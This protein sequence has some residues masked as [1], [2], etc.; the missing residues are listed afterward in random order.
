MPRL[1][2]KIKLTWAEF[3]TQRNA[4]ERFELYLPTLKL[5]Q[6]QLQLTI[7][8]TLQEHVALSSR[9]EAV[10]KK[11]SAYRPVFGDARRHFRAGG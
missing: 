6:Q 8:K 7:A 3:R 4:L 2:K 11:I 1:K 10:E 9:M 5:K